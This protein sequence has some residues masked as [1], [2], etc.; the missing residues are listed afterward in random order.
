[1]T[2][3]SH[4]CLQFQA[5]D[6]LW[7]LWAPGTH[8]GHKHAGKTPIHVKLAKQIISGTAWSPGQGQHLSG[9][10]AVICSQHSDLEGSHCTRGEAGVGV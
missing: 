1:M 4:L 2:A 3:Q 5:S 6:A 10:S 7:P 9:V 8:L